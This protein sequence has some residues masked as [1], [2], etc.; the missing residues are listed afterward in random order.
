MPM[1]KT[2]KDLEREKIMREWDYWRKEI[3][4]GFKGSAARDWFE[5]VLDYYDEKVEKN[6]NYQNYLLELS[7]RKH[8]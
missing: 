7:E 1:P 4:Q 3:S 6:V 2:I 8:R 5:S